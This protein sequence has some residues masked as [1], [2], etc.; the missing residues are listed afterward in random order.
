MRK[1]IFIHTLL[2]ALATTSAPARDQH[3]VVLDIADRNQIFID[4]RFLLEKQNVRIVVCPPEKTREKCLIGK[5]MK[6]LRGYGNIMV[7]IGV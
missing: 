4:E 1:P 7:E 6:V 3:G 2:L 5:G